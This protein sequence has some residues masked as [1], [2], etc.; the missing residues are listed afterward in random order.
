MSDNK[1]VVV[2]CNTMNISAEIG[3][4]RSVVSAEFSADETILVV[5]TDGASLEVWDFPARQELL[6]ITG[7][8]RKVC[9]Y[10]ISPDSKDVAI[11]HRDGAVCIW[12]VAARKVQHTCKAHSRPINEVRFS[13]NGTRLLSASDDGTACIFDTRTWTRIATLRGDTGRMIRCFFVPDSE[14]ILTV[15]DTTAIWDIQSARKLFSW[16]TEGYVSAISPDGKHIVLGSG[17]A[18]P[19]IWF[20][21][22]PEDWWGVL[23]TPG[24]WLVAI[25]SLAALWSIRRDC[26]CF[27]RKDRKDLAAR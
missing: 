11:A 14:R 12:N 15:S 22:H 4:T 3:T 13:P 9:A 16:N 17:L 23:V 26:L 20:Q 18:R 7:E 25:C 10:T 6:Q 27:A 19:Q 24:F 8:G 1:V 21:Q 5:A 2:D